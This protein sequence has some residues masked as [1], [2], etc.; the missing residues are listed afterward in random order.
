MVSI[1]Q[2]KRRLKVFGT[3]TERKKIRSGLALMAKYGWDRYL[4][5]I[6]VIKALNAVSHTAG[7]YVKGAC[8]EINIE[9]DDLKDDVETAGT[10]TH[11]AIHGREIAKEGVAALEQ[12]DEIR[13]HE[14]TKRLFEEAMTIEDRP[15]HLGR[16]E[17]EIFQ[18]DTY[19][20]KLKEDKLFRLAAQR[21]QEE[22]F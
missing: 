2:H 17:E 18:Q 7:P 10:I 21:Q 22:S 15:S 4:P 20:A 8:V 6:C 3:P 12:D 13:A 9:P 11:E 14:E 1:T 16:L 19:I 5:N